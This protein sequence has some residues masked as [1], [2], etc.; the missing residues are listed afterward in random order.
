MNA[1]EKAIR[2]WG[3]ENPKTIVIAELFE[4]NREVVAE[5]L[6]ILLNAE[7]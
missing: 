5:A 1:L 7:E 2:K 4:E 6:W 3:F